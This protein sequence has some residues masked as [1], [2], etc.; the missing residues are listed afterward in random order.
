MLAV[1]SRYTTVWLRNGKSIRASQSDYY[2]F[3][4]LCRAGQ[5]GLP[6]NDGNRF[7]ECILLQIIHTRQIYESR[8]L[9]RN[10]RIA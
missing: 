10:S 6:F 1:G 3:A 7:R 2:D 5:E 8:P 9:A 4:M